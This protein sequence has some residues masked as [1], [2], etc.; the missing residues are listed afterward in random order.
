MHR[1]KKTYVWIMLM[2]LIVSLFPTGL[3]Q[4]VHAAPAQPATYFIPDDLDLRKTSLL[5]TDT[6]GTQISRENVYV[7]SSPTLTITGTYAYV[8]EDSLKAK[9]EQLSS[10]TLQGGGIEWVTD[11]AHFKD[12]NITKDSSSSA[13]KFKATNLSLFPGFNK[14]TLSGSQNGIT[15]SD[16]FYVL[17]DQVPYVQNLKLLGSSLGEIYLNEGTQV[18]SDKQS[19]TLQGDVKNAT[20]VTVAVNSDTPLVSTLTQTGKFFSPALKLKTGLN[21][22]TI[23]IKNGSDSVS[24]TREVYYYDKNSPFVTLDMNYNGKDYNLLNNTPTVTDNG[25]NGTPSGT[26][27]ARVLL[28]DTGKPFK[29]AGTVLID[30]NILT[31]NTDYSVLDEVAIPAPDGVT[32]AYRLVTLKV[33]SLAFAAGVEAQ[34]IKLGVSYDN[35]IDAATDLIFKY[36]PGEVGITNMKYLKGYQE[37]NTL[38]ATSVLPLD[39]TELESDSFYVLVQADQNLDGIT[40][41]PV[42]K[43]EY[44]PTGSVNVTKA[45]SQPS[46]LAKNE[47]VYKVTGFSNGKQ[48]VRF[49]FN[50][51]S[52]YYTV[53]I[54]YATKN[55]IYVENLYDGQTFE[56][57]SS[58]GTSTIRLK[59][60][61]RDFENISNAE[62]FVNGLTGADLKLS[63]PFKVDNTTK[64]FDL[65]LTVD[66]SGP[67]Y[68]G[69]NRIVLTGSSMDGKG[70]TRS[71]RKELRIY[72]VDTNVSNITTFQPSIADDANRESFSQLN[73]GQTTSNP[74]L[75]KILERSPLFEYKDNIYET[76]QLKYDLVIQGGGAKIINLN[77]GSQK[78][79]SSLDQNIDLSQATAGTTVIKTDKFQYNGKDYDYD[80][81][82]IDGKFLLRIRN[83]PFEAPGSH[84]YNLELINSTGARSSQ[85]LE[86]TRVVAPFRI[87]SPKATVG[88]QIVVNKNFVRFDIEAEGATQVL[89]NKKPATKRTDMNDRF[90]YDF[91][92]LKP[93]KSTSIKIEIVRGTTSV[94]Q[95]VN[96][97]YTSTVTVD[98]QYMTEKPATKYSAFNKALELS[99]PKGTVLKSANVGVGEVAKFYPD[100]KYLFGI[101][102]P[103]DGV[104]ERKNDYGDVIGL[105]KDQRTPNGQETIKLPVDLLEF[106]NSTARTYNFTRVSNVYWISAGLGE[107][108]SPETPGYKPST[109]GLAPYSIEGNFR[110]LSILEPERKIVPSQRGTLTIAFN[111]D[112]VDAAGT[113]VTVF[114]F[115]DKAE[116]ENVGG[117]VNTKA[118]TI[119]VPFDDSGYYVVMKQSRGFSDITKHPWARDILNALYAKGIMSNV[120]ADAFGA[121]DL[122]TRGEFA[123]LLVKGLDIPL[124]YDNNVQTYFDIVPGA[125]TD[126]WDFKYIETA[127]RAGIVTGI[128][129]GYFGVEEPITREQA[130]VMVARAL[131]LK[132]P[133]NDAKLKASL[134]KQFQDSGKIDIYARPG[135]SAVVSAKIMAGQPIT[136][137]GQKKPSYNFNPQSSMTR[138]EAGKIAVE[139]LKKS[140]SIFPKNLS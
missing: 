18:V 42:L 80:L 59:G 113:T 21:T 132:M 139:L 89:I 64:T 4:P 65:N 39:G 34:K 33:N 138:A 7:S 111:P 30:N 15:R 61:Y 12:G 125:K 50:D 71:V 124:N 35:K 114:R 20:D 11:S 92:G 85:R 83:I 78:F 104:L 131:K 117:A 63:T 28:D 43:A 40:P 53:N 94:T 17:F 86:I 6:S 100:N 13:Q 56:I 118:H 5:T 9:V 99:F 135:I 108:G 31:P 102:D 77:L 120:Q 79:F 38:A 96:V 57:D 128:G 49:H 103:K 74:K 73:L 88:E 93:D 68:Y 123:T 44:L 10:K 66:V 54:T 121:D 119:T 122:T 47:V 134:D 2:A 133:A 23:T 55:Y 70:N 26:L 105:N 84:V 109:N 91:V 75:D 137:T 69:E 82:M 115:T 136:I 3:A 67:L 110:D 116:W 8:T 107:A 87:L 60:E 140:T 51:S 22:L 97:Y 46:D 112:V 98:S 76:S 52:A 32:P 90:F 14:I 129:E 37:G 81:A 25:Q 48:Q 95:T 126:T 27:T 106:F 62:L 29:D 24:V 101:A 19:V 130:A 45:G 58:K 16:V 41:E 127:S 72:I 1:I 36:L